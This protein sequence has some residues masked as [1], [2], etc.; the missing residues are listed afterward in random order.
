M[1]RK[2]N[3]IL[4]IDDDEATNFMHERIIKKAEVTDN[5][6][7]VENGEEAMDYIDKAV[8]G[9]VGFPEIIF[10][11]INMPRMNGWEFLEEYEKATI[12]MGTRC[13]VVVMLTTSLNPA[14]REKAEQI[15][16]ICQFHTKPLS[17][18]V[19]EQVVNKCACDED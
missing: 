6:V 7:V 16:S 17:G 14:D 5:I 19:V 2:L 15:G 9:E 8:K 10:L 18:D 12:E 3:T 1:A 11:D 4:L 13:N